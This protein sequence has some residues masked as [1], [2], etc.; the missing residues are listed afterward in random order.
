MLMHHEVEAETTEARK[1]KIARAE[2]RDPRT[3]DSGSGTAGE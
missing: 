2:E 1:D 3:S